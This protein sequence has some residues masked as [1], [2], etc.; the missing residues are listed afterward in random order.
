MPIKIYNSTSREI[1]DYKRFTFPAG[2]VGIKI[3]SY[4]SE[5]HVIG[6]LVQFQNSDDIIALMMIVDALRRMKPKVKIVLYA[7]YIPYARQDRVM[8][9]GESLSIK[10]FAD[11]INSLN[12]EQVG[13]LDPHSD[14][15][16]ALIE[17][18]SIVTNQ[19]DIFKEPFG[20]KFGDWANY[21]I[22]APDAGAQKRAE[23]FAKDVGA[24][25]VVSA[26]KSRDVSTGKITSI[27]L[28]ENV[29]GDK[30]V[31]VDDLIDGGGTFIGLAE[32]LKECAEK[33]LIVTHGIFSKG[34]DVVLEH[35]DSVFTTNSYKD[36]P[37]DIPKLYVVDIFKT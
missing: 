13:I 11:I 31:V 36:I 5:N 27:K 14:V 28:T 15:T 24:K 4:F 9:H 33:H 6:L 1:I 7:P 22:I 16:S 21:T 17:R 30:V 25:R 2:E 35:Y 8:T 37:T 32:S 12:F 26:I 3:N 10:V 19:S 29:S 34:Y 18:C 20:D 23:K